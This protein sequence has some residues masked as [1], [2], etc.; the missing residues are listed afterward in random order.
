MTH[1]EDDDLQA[2]PRR[3]MVDVS[4]V[5]ARHG[6]S[7]TWQ[8]THENGLGLSLRVALRALAEVGG[9]PDD[10]ELV[11]MLERVAIHLASEAWTTPMW[12]ATLEERGNPE[13]REAYGAS[14]G[15]QNFAV[16]LL[17]D[18]S[19]PAVAE[20]VESLLQAVAAGCAAADHLPEDSQIEA[21]LG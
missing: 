6:L 11:H 20:R 7:A 16:E 21:L 17:N 5:I 8:W 14:L 18:Y 12:W 4:G 10:D 9:D 2:T 3:L 1:P 13:A 15:V 19:S